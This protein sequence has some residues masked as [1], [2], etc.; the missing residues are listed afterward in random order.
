M[1][2]GDCFYGYSPDFISRHEILRY[3]GKKMAEKDELTM[4]YER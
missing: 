2:I 3:S 1:D 4:K